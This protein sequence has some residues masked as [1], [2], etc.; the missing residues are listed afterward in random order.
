MSDGSRPLPLGESEIQ[1]PICNHSQA[2]EAPSSESADRPRSPVMNK[3][4]NQHEHSKQS[5]YPK[6]SATST[7]T[8]EP[9]PFSSVPLNNQPLPTQWSTGQHSSMG[10]DVTYSFYP[11]LALGNIHGIP[12]QDVNFLELQG[13]LRVPTRTILDEFVQQYFLHVH[14]LLPMLNEGDFWA[15][16]CVNP[17]NY[18]SNDKLSLLVFQAMLFASCN[19]SAWISILASFY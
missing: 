12:P 10:I 1:P 11:F 7:S 9:F 8:F 14:P 2:H 18:V 15:V 13:C 3:N 4:G 6:P 17:A 19:V 16:Y 5:H